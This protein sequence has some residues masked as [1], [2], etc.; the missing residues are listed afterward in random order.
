MSVLRQ[1]A[2]GRD[3]RAT[4]AGSGGWPSAYREL[5]AAVL[6]SYIKALQA[7]ERRQKGE[8]ID[9]PPVLEPTG[10]PVANEGGTLTKHGIHGLA[11]GAGAPARHPIQWLKRSA[12]YACLPSVMGN[13]HRGDQTVPRQHVPRGVA[14]RAPQLL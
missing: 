14:G 12:R 11:E 7:I 9:A 8:P 2:H 4:D 6:K 5:G 1:P 10:T 13:V 3:V